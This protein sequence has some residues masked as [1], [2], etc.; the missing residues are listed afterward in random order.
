MPNMDNRGGRTRVL[1]IVLSTVGGLALL[2]FFAFFALV[3]SLFFR[4]GITPSPLISKRAGVGIVKV[5]G[6]ISSPEKIL[7]DLRQFRDNDHVK[8]IVLRIDSPGGAVG[9]SQE[10]YQEIRQID[11]EKPVV[12]SLVNTAASG[13][14]YVACA[15]RWIVSDPGT[16]TGSIGVIMKLPNIAGLLEKLGIKTTV[17]KSGKLKDLASITR[18]LTPEERQVIKGVMDDIHQQFIQDVAKGRH[19]PIEEVSKVADGRIFSGKQ[20]LSLH[21]VDEIGNFSTAVK[22][23]AELGK[24]KGRPAL[25]YPEKD[26]I[27]AIKEI[28]EDSEARSMIKFLH[29]LLRDGSSAPY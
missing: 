11:R 16:V 15:S 12:A 4:S 9:A 7:R 6:V 26:K 13:A 19:L 1:L 10:I 17:I 20:A 23:A 14:F 3:V 8:A 22:K 28:L 21:F 5:D 24:I 25:I 27:T 18:D 2:V 29:L